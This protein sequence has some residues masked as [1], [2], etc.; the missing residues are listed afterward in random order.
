[1][2]LSVLLVVLLLGRA[3]RGGLNGDLLGAGALST[4]ALWPLLRPGGSAAVDQSRTREG[5]QEQVKAHLNSIQRPVRMSGCLMQLVAAVAALSRLLLPQ[6]A[7]LT[8][9]QQHQ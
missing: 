9:Q 4:T 2:L 7:Q 3:E 6:S 5:L 1:M 8:L